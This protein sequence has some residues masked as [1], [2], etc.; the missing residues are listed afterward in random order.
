MAIDYITNKKGIKLVNISADELVDKN[1]KLPLGLTWSC[2]NRF[3]IEDIS[4]EEAT[5]RCSPSYLVPKRT[6]KVMKVL[7]LQTS[8][9]HGHQVLPSVH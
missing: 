9:H 1:P 2:I 8:Q 4:V 7:T 5:A 6:H 3:A